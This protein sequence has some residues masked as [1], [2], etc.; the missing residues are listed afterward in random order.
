MVK[1]EDR[2]SPEL[3]RERIKEEY[4]K[5]A[6]SPQYFLT[7]YCYI[8]HPQRGK[9]L[10]DLYQYQSNV[11]DDFIEHDYNIV[12]KGRQI[13]ISTAAAG[14]SLWLLLFHR[15]KNI[16][17]IA[18]KQDTAKNL[19]SKVRFMHENLPVWLRGK[20]KT[21]N[22]LSLEFT[23][24]SQIKAVASSKDAGRSEALSLLILD[25]CA[26]IEEADTIWT[27]AS[28]T[29]ST[30]GKALLL[31]TPNGVGNFFH[32]T[33]NTAVEGGNDFNP[34]LLDW[35][36]HPDRDQAWRDRQT[37]LLGE[38]EATQE[39]DASFIFSGNTVIPPE[40]IEFYKST[41]VQ[42]PLSKEGFDGNV[43]IWEYPQSGRTYIVCADVS[44]GDGDDY[45][46]YHVI[47][48][49]TSCQVAEYKGKVETKQFGDMLV[50]ISTTYN[51][52]LL[53]PDNSNIGWNTI[54]QIIDRGYR[55]LFYMS[56][57]LQYVDTQHQM[58]PNNREKLV[59]GFTISQRTRPVIV[60]RLKEYMLD[61][62]FTIRSQRTIS[63][64]E[65]FIW[66]RGRAEAMKNYNDDLIF[67]LCIGLWVRD[68][69]L[70]LR[71][72]G[73][74]LTRAALDNTSVVTSAGVYVNKNL[75]SDPYEFNVTGEITENIKW[76]L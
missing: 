16:L 42:E 47:D 49:E 66:Q 27:A 17:V 46:A 62:S 11:I 61:Y 65:T 76:L 60:G 13:G 20:T 9:I 68:T 56:N 2:T 45:S 5:C 7:K 8:Q 57:D 64:M 35:R 73:I 55:N 12:L 54:Q 74:E 39:H 25:E 69:A 63:E 28:S 1:K 72:Q 14:F 19:V 44:R 6:L 31:S 22:K 37:E 10:F 43:W 50:S 38:V 67:A 24:G 23:N 4:K 34:I 26:F 21:D 15:D 18:T 29:L 48:A 70:R 59:P 41:Y 58:D 30:G 51:D 32:K 71:Q 36:V 3:L 53:I 75:N 33:W 40:I 52:A